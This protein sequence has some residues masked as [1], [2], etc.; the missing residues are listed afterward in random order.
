MRH[1]FLHLSCI[2]QN[3]RCR[4]NKVIRVSFYIPKIS[5][6]NRLFL[7][8]IRGQFRTFSKLLS[9]IFRLFLNQ[10]LPQVGHRKAHFMHFHPALT[11][12][13]INSICLC[14]MHKFLVNFNSTSSWLGRV[15]TCVRRHVFFRWYANSA[16]L[17]GAL[18]V[19]QLFFINDGNWSNKHIQL[20]W[21][22]AF[23]MIWQYMCIAMI[24]PTLHN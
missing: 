23:I 14:S 18:H 13:S 7:P 1:T 6:F 3:F 4:I 17:L 8:Y 15:C 21:A 19:S 22:C 5:F 10:I 9:P 16:E 24:L 20:F 12:Y 2:F 11:S